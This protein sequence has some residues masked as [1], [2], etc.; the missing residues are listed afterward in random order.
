MDLLPRS[1]RRGTTTC[2]DL[3]LM[4]ILSTYQKV[5]LPVNFTKYFDTI[6]FINNVNHAL[7][8]GFWLNK[9]FAYFFVECVKGKARLVK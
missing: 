8:Y 1:E 4:E 6:I 7:P 5:R 2:P 3:Y 9:V